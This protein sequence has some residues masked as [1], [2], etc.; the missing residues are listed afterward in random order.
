VC[1]ANRGN[2]LEA[3]YPAKACQELPYSTKSYGAKFYGSKVLSPALC[4][5]ARILGALGHR[6]PK[7]RF[8]QS[9]AGRRF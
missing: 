9:P 2:A 7:A 4:T 3:R 6:Y 8:G 5:R 1:L